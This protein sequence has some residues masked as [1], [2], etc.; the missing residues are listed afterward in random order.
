M[1]EHSD[2]EEHDVAVLTPLDLKDTDHH[3]L[4]IDVLNTH[5]RYLRNPQD[6]SVGRYHK[7]VVL[8]PH[9]LLARYQIDWISQKNQRNLL[10]AISSML[11]M[12]LIAQLSLSFEHKTDEY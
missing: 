2:G 9:R 4:T 12:V 8:E 1:K 11:K 5:G 10:K 7:G 6:G 3:A